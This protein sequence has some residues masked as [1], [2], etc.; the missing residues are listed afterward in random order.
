MHS[1]CWCSPVAAVTEV[2]FGMSNGRWAPPLAPAACSAPA[3]GSSIDC[4]LITLW[5]RVF[6]SSSESPHCLHFL[7]FVVHSFRCLPLSALSCCLCLPASLPVTSQ[8]LATASRGWRSLGGRRRRQRRPPIVAPCSH[9]RR[10]LRNRS[11][12]KSQKQANTFVQSYM[13]WYMYIHICICMVCVSV[14]TS[15]YRQALA[16]QAQA[17]IFQY[18]NVL[19][20]QNGAADAVERSTWDGRGRCC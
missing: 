7:R 15:I 5:K 14:Y 19:V 6:Y 3:D 12:H 16:A 11:H 9:A 2:F 17:I 1:S 20:P 10:L 8:V 18:S 13:H 4:L